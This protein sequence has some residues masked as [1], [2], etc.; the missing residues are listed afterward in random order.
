V[1]AIDVVN[2][3][4]TYRK[5]ARRRQFATLKSA[6][7]SGTLVNDLNPDE[8]FNAL[9][10]VSFSVRQ[11]C[12]F[13][14]V[15]RN[16]SGKSTAL[17]VVAGITKPT[18]GTVSVQGRISALIELGAGF[19]PEISGRENVF[20]NGI[21]LGLS[22]REITRRFDEIVEFAEIEDF[23]DAP[24]KTYS[25]GMYMRLGFAVAIH[26]DPDV[27]LI[28][29]VLAVGDEAFTHKC[30]DKF[31]EFR[32]RNKTVLLVTHSLNLVERFCDEALWLNDGRSRAMGDPR[33]VVSAY[34][35]DVEKQEERH[36][37]EAD[38]R[39][40]ATVDGSS[41][42]S[43]NSGSEGLGSPAT[44]A[45]TA[46][47]AGSSDPGTPKA[48]ETPPPPDM[49]QA[50][51]GRWGSREGEITGVQLVGEDGAAAHVFF[52]GERVEIRL[53]LRA[54]TPL[55]DFVVGIGMFNVDGVCAFGTNTNI[56]ELK[57]DRLEG[58][59]RVTFAIDGLDLVAGTYK[60][61]VALHKLDGYPYDYH[62]L[63]YSFRVKSRTQDAGIYRPRHTWTFDGGVTF[64]ERVSGP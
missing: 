43:R 31:A 29:E 12:T 30:L 21:M 25:S 24:V 64:K 55:T 56:E 20:I 58:E 63:L 19:H 1:H 27:L 11:G 18:T 23:I 51:E 42:E 37:A 33:R 17:K 8:T 2:V 32:R 10:G 26:V 3:T 49:F 7:L 40:Q 47:S 36:M 16:G 45:T 53:T 9:K 14:I 5:Y 13:G 38:A 46:A 28:D 4:K 61:D 60:L 52:S 34:I 35:T 41:Q 22:K 59:G 44:P 54:A 6:I 50:T 57:A 15:G 39:A 62:R 48:Q